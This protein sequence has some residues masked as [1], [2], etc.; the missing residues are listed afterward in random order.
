M[1]LSSQASA[2]IAFDGL[3]TALTNAE[4]FP[5]ERSRHAE[6]LVEPNGHSKIG[7]IKIYGERNTGT[8]FLHELIQQNFAV[9]I[10][11][12]EAARREI[13]ERIRNELAGKLHLGAQT[14]LIRRIIL[15]RLHD[16]ENHRQVSATLGWKH[17]RPPIEV[18]VKQGFTAGTLF[19]VVA[20][21]PVFWALSF[22]RRPYHDYLRFKK[23]G[24]S[25][26]IRHMFIPTDRDNVDVLYHRS[27]LELYAAKVDGYRELAELG[28]PFE[29]VR[30]EDLLSDTSGFV[31]ALCAKHGLPRVSDD[32]FVPPLSTKGD[33]RALDD[34]C[35]LY[36]LDNVAQAV[37][38]EDYEFILSV[39]SAERLRWL[40]YS[41]G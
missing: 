2:K 39:F 8:R 9:T 7:Q 15:N 26:F 30:Y 1:I 35:S 14:R 19:L 10:L 4:P 25:E 20:K 37:S 13:A 24:F 33:E 27:P 31:Q 22:H 29:L 34:L 41:A 17:M 40:G 36:R 5:E 12:P 16:I 23:M 11:S 6:F 32:V 21:H 28:V 38:H 18:I 3:V